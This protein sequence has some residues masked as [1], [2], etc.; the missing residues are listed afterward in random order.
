M[1]ITFII[2]HAQNRINEIINIENYTS[3]TIYTEYNKNILNKF[4]EKLKTLPYIRHIEKYVYI[5]ADEHWNLG[6][7]EGVINIMTPDEL[8]LYDK[9]DDMFQKKNVVAIQQF[10]QDHTLPNKVK[11]HFAYLLKA[12]MSDNLDE[13]KFIID[14][15]A[16]YWDPSDIDTM[17]QYCYYAV[18]N[19]TLE[20]FEYLLSKNFPCDISCVLHASTN[21]WESRRELETKLK[22]LYPDIIEL[23]E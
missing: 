5:N 11:Y 14:N 15:D 6:I 12:I 16:Y 7:P 22:I 13:I 1:H 20:I 8:V 4:L 2:K 23:V 10:V 21:Q 18:Q 19:S 9:Y 17:K 3:I